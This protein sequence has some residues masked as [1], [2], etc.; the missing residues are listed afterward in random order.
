MLLILA[1]AGWVADLSTLQ[2]SAP[3]SNGKRINRAIE[4]LD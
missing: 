3:S 4:L 1:V 2:S